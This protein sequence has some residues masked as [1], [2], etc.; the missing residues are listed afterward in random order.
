MG[1]FSN[2]VRDSQKPPPA[3]KR[4]THGAEPHSG[5]AAKA[6]LPAESRPLGLEAAAPQVAHRPYEPFRPAVGEHTDR[7]KED[8]PAEALP[9]KPTIRQ[10]ED[11]SSVEPTRATMLAQTNDGGIA[12]P[13]P[14]IRRQIDRPS[15]RPATAQTSTNRASTS[16]EAVSSGTESANH[17]DAVLVTPTAKRPKRSSREP[18]GKTPESRPGEKIAWDEIA[19]PPSQSAPNLWSRPA[20]PRPVL[21]AATVDVDSS[22]NAKPVPNRKEGD[23]ASPAEAKPHPSE[24]PETPPPGQQTTAPGTADLLLSTAAI[25]VSVEQMQPDTLPESGD[26]TDPPPEFRVVAARPAVPIRIET[27]AALAPVQYQAEGQAERAPSRAVPT[28]ECPKVQIGLLEVVM[29]APASEPKGTYLANKA[30]T[31]IASRHYLRNI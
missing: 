13:N 8:G 6:V 4:V 21:S 19:A 16:N 27:P 25:P 9:M 22:V 20:S 29:Q 14:V 31:N 1:F 26:D 28:P 3:A 17:A 11:P 18:S 30:R 10:V 23:I 5:G 12:A 7:R 15:R 24:S 2:I